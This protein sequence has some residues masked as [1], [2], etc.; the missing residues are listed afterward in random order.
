MKIM[1]SDEDLKEG[2]KQRLEIKVSEELL[3]EFIS[4]MEA[5]ISQWIHDNLKAFEEV[6][7]YEKRL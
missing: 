6:L 1:V 2:L 4:Y 3:K 7:R 5:D